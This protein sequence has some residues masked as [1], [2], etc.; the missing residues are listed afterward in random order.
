MVKYIYIYIYII[1]GEKKYVAAI[2]SHIK[3]EEP[4]THSA[5]EDLLSSLH[6]QS[7]PK[8]TN[9]KSY[10]DTALGYSTCLTT[11]GMGCSKSLGFFP[12]HRKNV[13]T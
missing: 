5:Y 3:E 9:D 12:D 10:F 6:K 11:C 1:C 4:R 13:V 7:S 8:G 2:L